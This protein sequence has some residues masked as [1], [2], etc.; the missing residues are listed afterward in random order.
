MTHTQTHTQYCMYR[1]PENLINNIVHLFMR[2]LIR[3][4]YKTLQETLPTI[5]YVYAIIYY[6]AL[7]IL[8]YRTNRFIRSH[9]E[10][11]VID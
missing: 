11:G 4:P 10:R 7:F 9:N 8:G 3:R 6:D 2:K 1:L 5:N